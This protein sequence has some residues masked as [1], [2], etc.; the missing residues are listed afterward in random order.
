MSERLPT[1]RPREVVAALARA[2]FVLH[3]Q[4]GSHAHY[5]KGN[6]TVTVP[7]HGGDVGHG[8]LR[9]ILRQARMTPEEFKRWL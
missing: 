6:L 8:T 1:V 4:R 7:M 5:R 3:R 9:S 2:G